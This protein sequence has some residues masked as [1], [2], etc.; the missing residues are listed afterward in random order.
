MRCGFTCVF[1]FLCVVAGFAQETPDTAQELARMRSELQETRAQLA[2]SVRQ[3][4]ELRQSLEE[5]RSQVNANPSARTTAS[6]SPSASAADQDVGFLAAKVSELHQD[7]IESASKFPVKISGLVLFNAY[8]NSGPV[9]IQDVPSLAFPGT[10]GTSNGGIGAT[11]R[12]TLI[13]ISTTGPKLF[14]AQSSADVSIDFAGGSPTTPYG[15]T[16]GLMRMRTSNVRLSWPTTTLTFG[17]D[18]PFFSPLSPTSY[19]TLLEPALSWSGNLWVWTPQ[20]EIERKAALNDHSSLLFQGGLLDPLTEEPPPFQGRDPTSGERTRTPGIA[21]RVAYDRTEGIPFTLGFGGYRA[22]QRH[23]FLPEFA[24]WTVNADFKASF[25]NRA[26]LSGEWYRGLAAGGLGGGIWTS[27]VYPDTSEPA[28]AVHPLRSIGGWTQLKILPA[29]RFEINAAA[30]QDENFGQD[31]RFFPNPATEYGNIAFQKNRTEFVNLIYKP[32]SVLLFST[33]YRRLFT[34]Q[35]NGT[36]ASGN[37]LNLAAG[38][39]F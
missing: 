38:V 22:E 12:Q 2:D 4:S 39:R 1:L 26:Q 35:A 32:N 33:E 21:G 36:S 34:L 29:P 3:V 7:K 5:L 30:G 19:A 18:T 28:T 37:H 27:V 24:S 15:V 9:D 16:A 17:Q 31:L 13:G 10:P 20:I 11:L 6:S 8:G 23:D 14:G 25:G